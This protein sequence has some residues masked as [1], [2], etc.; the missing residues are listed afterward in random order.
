MTTF[1]SISPPLFLSYLFW[2]ELDLVQRINLATNKKVIVA[3]S[4]DPYVI[5]LSSTTKRVHWMDYDDGIFSS[6]YDGG[7]KTTVR[8]GSF[9]H[10]L[11]GIFKDSVFSQERND[12][13]INERNITSGKLFRNIKVVGTDLR[14]LVVVHSSL[15]QLGKF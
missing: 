7:T 5:S 13:Y 15:Q 8:S 12:P 4:A 11:L 6:S 2:T 14:D 10:L 3:R 9:N 1:F